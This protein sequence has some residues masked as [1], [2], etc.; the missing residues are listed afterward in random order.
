[1]QHKDRLSDEE[2]KARRLESARK[3]REK[4]REKCIAASLA[5][6]AKKPDH[7]SEKNREYKA[8]PGYIERQREYRAANRD[9]LI[10]STRRWQKSNRA[11]FNAYQHAYA[12]QNRDRMLSRQR[13]WRI[14]RADHIAAYTAAWRERSRHLLVI[15]EQRRRARIKGVGGN[16]SPDIH[17]RLMKLQ[18]GKCAVCRTSLQRIRPH[19]D[20]I[21]PIAK[22]GSNTD[23]NV[24]LL[25]P[26]CNACKHAKHP[27]DFMQERGFLC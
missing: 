22:G 11:R 6:R 4:N 24:Q 9:R 7:Y 2:R 5:S 12:R 10:A 25:C 17:A 14:D 27:V 15:K 13:K 23:G 20:H 19:I 3:Y 8:D 26:H 18:K 1:M 16:L 21:M